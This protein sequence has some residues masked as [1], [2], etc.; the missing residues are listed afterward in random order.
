MRNLVLVASVVLMLAGCAKVCS[1]AGCM[2]VP[3]WWASD[4]APEK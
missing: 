4:E 2:Y 3:I 1:H